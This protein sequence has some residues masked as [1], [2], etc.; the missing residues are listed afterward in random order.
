MQLVRIYNDGHGDS[1]FEDMELVGQ[2]QLSSTGAWTE[3]SEPFAVDSVVLRDVISEAPEG[4]PHVSPARII[5]VPLVGTVEVEASDGE[6]RRFGP[7]EL[8]LLED[9]VGKGHITRNIGSHRRSTLVIALRAS[10]KAP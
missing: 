10:E 3:V 9:M 2:A 4:A 8:V 1:H 7:G 6:T 5:I